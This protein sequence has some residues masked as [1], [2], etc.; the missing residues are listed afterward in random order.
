[1]FPEYRAVNCRDSRLLLDYPRRPGHH[2]AVH[3]YH[4]G[5]VKL[6][7]ADR[8]REELR[9]ERE[10][11]MKDLNAME[12]AVLDIPAYC[13]VATPQDFKQRAPNLPEPDDQNR[14]LGRRLRQHALVPG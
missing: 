2:R 14:S 8:G 13:P 4:V 7:V 9:T 5:L 6:G 1:M 12:R 3:D 11:Q 10:A